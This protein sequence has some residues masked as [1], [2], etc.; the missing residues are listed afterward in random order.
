[1]TNGE[2]LLSPFGVFE[3][4]VARHLLLGRHLDVKIE[5]VKRERRCCKHI[6]SEIWGA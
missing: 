1:M 6:S 5:L 3:V 4:A 2:A